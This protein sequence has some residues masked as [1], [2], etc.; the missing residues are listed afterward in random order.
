MGGVI[1]IL[2]TLVPV[3]LVGNLG[4]IYMLLMIFAT[5]WLGA[6]GFADDYLKLSRHNKDGMKGKFK[7][8]G[9]VGLGVVVGL[10]M[11]LSPDIVMRENIESPASAEITVESADTEVVEHITYAPEMK[12]PRPLS[13]LSKTTTSTIPGSPHGWVITPPSVDG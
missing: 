10:T 7:I 12:T 11:Y 8:I 13:P 1:I 5:V 4:S 3:A 6:L 2:S 9:Q